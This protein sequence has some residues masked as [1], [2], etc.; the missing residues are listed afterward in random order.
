MFRKKTLLF[1]VNI[2]LQLAMHQHW[3]LAM[4]QAEADADPAKEDEKKKTKKKISE[5]ETNNNK[6]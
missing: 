3:Q 4:L 2:I 5:E 1:V 6:R